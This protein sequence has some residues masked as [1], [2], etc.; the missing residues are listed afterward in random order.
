M[1]APAID[2]SCLETTGGML[3]VLEAF[4]CLEHCVSKNRQVAE[5]PGILWP[6]VTDESYN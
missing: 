4:E 3:H 2:N 5:R 6:F 1:L